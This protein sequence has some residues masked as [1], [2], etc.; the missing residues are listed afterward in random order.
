M[1]QAT[2]SSLSLSSSTT[3]TPKGKQVVSFAKNKVRDK[4]DIRGTSTQF[5][6]D[7]RENLD[8]KELLSKIKSAKSG[9][10]KKLEIFD[11]SKLITGDSNGK[12]ALNVIETLEEFLTEFD[13]HLTQYDKCHQDGK[14]W[15]KFMYWNLETY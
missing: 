11:Y 1:V 9:A 6:K 14:E 15:Q 10:S 8:E 5:T 4:K 7:M 12:A 2:S 3:G 13:D